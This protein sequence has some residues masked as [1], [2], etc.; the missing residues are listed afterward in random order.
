VRHFC[1]VKLSVCFSLFCAVGLWAD[2]T[3]DRAAIDRV[4]AALND[5]VQRAGLLT[6]DV[7]S[8]VDFDRLIDLHRK[9]TLS[10]GVVIGINETWTELTV[11]RAVSGRIRFITPSVAMVDGASTI[12]GAVT[13]APR[14]PLLFVM[15]KAETG[16]RISAVRGLTTAH[17]SAHSIVLPQPRSGVTR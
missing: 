7:D 2:E 4:I 13:L 3:Q 9:D 14:V 11:P 16:W 6:S 12:R 8:G 15:K 5:P 17:S 10:V 1:G